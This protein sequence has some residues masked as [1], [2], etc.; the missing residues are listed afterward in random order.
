MQKV[1]G[2]GPMPVAANKRSPSRLTPCRDHRNHF[3]AHPLA[4]ISENNSAFKENNVS[5]ANAF[6]ADALK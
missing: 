2:V 1:A 5:K 3:A 6:H 4:L